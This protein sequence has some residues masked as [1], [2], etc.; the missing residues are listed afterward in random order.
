MA[1]RGAYASALMWS[2]E[3]SLDG[4]V[5]RHALPLIS[6]DM[7]EAMVCLEGIC[8]KTDRLERTPDGGFQ[9]VGWEAVQEQTLAAKIAAARERKRLNKANERRRVPTD[10]ATDGATDRAT[11]VGKGRTEKDRPEQA[12]AEKR[13]EEE[14]SRSYRRGPRVDIP[15][16]WLRAAWWL[17]L[18][19]SLRGLYV[20]AMMLSQE[21]KKDG[22]LPSWCL[23]L[24][25]V[26]DMEELDYDFDQIAR[27]NPDRLR[28][29]TDGW[30]LIGWESVQLQDTAEQI[31]GRLEKDRFRKAQ[32]RD[33]ERETDA[34]RML[35]PQNI[36]E[37]G[38]GPVD[39]EASACVRCGLIPDPPTELSAGYLC[40]DCSHAEASRDEEAPLGAP[41]TSIEATKVGESA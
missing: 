33:A 36:R 27:A 16:T 12:R 38:E 9:F 6:R 21:Q 17:K 29:V 24:L 32:A 39:Q 11:D 15:C 23:H 30:E 4:A 8:D 10:V 18:P 19:L 1:E 41:S 37:W 35:Q 22:R 26:L 3:Q 28:R 25:G 20:T 7:D 13:Q 2:Q 5:N 34:Q 31:A 40:S 14:S